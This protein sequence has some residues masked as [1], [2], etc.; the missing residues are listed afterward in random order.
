MD[1][2]LN[3]IKK[4]PQVRIKVNDML[5]RYIRLPHI[6]QSKI[7]YDTLIQNVILKN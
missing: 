7:G 5:D 1:D 3:V 6:N 4:D 2:F